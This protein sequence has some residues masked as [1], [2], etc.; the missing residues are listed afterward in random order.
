MEKVELF[1]E[2]KSMVPSL[3][4]GDKLLVVTSKTAASGDVVVFKSGT[5]II[6]HRIVKQGICKGDRSGCTEE[7]DGFMGVVVGVNR[8]RMRYI[9]G[10]DGQ[11]FKNVIAFCS[12]QT[13]FGSWRIKRYFFLCLISLVNYVSLKLTKKSHI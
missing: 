4:P 9:W 1:F 3:L 6:A 5:K 12:R 13:T 8:K 2:G 10:E 7:V 11:P